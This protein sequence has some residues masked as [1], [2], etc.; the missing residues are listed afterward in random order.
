MNRPMI[1]IAVVAMLATCCATSGD[2]YAAN[3]PRGK[4]G[5]QTAARKQEND[6][7]KR[8]LAPYLTDE[9]MSGRV[10]WKEYAVNPKAKGEPTLLVVFGGRDSVRRGDVP[11]ATPPA[12]GKALV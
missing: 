5:M 11:G 8:K 9:G 4:F 7:M 2:A 12:V 10:S 6:D 3:P 1:K